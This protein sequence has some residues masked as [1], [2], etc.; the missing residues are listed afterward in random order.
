MILLAKFKLL[1]TIYLLTVYARL[2]N[3]HFF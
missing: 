3:L 2:T 1:E